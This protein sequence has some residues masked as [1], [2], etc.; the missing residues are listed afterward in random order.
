M[1]IKKYIIAILASLGLIGGATFG[2]GYYNSP[3]NV[4]GYSFYATSTATR[5]PIKNGAGVLHCIVPS[6]TTTGVTKFYNATTS[7][8]SLI[9]TMGAGAKGSFCFDAEVT[10]GISASSTVSTDTYT[11]TY[12]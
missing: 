3:T 12:K 2:A 4:S 1:N 8:G 6:V 9:H 5:G 10:V 7:T 11:V